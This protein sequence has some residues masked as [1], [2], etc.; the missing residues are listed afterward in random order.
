MS[1]FARQ[2]G[3]TSATDKDSPPVGNF[4]FKV[5]AMVV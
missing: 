3:L 5:N 1:G 4:R 2:D